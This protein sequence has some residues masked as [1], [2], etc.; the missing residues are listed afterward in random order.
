M[1]FKEIQDYLLLQSQELQGLTDYNL[2]IIKFIINRVYLDIVKK[3]K[4]IED[5]VDITTVANQFSYSITDSANLAYIYKPYLVRYIRSGIDENGEKL[6]PYSGGYSNLPEN[7]TY[8]TPK[9]YWIRG[10]HT[11]SEIE[12]GTIPICATTGNTIRISAFMFPL[13]KL[14]VSMIFFPSIPFVLAIIIFLLLFLFF[15]Y[16]I[17]LIFF[18]FLFNILN[19]FFYFYLIFFEYFFYFYL[20]F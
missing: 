3:T 5:N 7:R 20:I 17:F 6:T 11:R 2:P 12:F 18:L 15:F 9:Q 13:T 1:T 19:I 16:L 8:G 14:R 10:L 4:C